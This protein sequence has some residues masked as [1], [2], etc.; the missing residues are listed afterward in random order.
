MMDESFSFLLSI[1]P[2][3]CNDNWVTANCQIGV[4]LLISQ[5]AVLA[6]HSSTQ[7]YFWKV[8]SAIHC[9]INASR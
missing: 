3:I 4:V 6:H 9:P 5:D 8:S 2:A 1:H 7:K